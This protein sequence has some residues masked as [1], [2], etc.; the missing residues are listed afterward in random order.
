MNENNSVIIISPESKTC[1]PIFFAIFHFTISENLSMRYQNNSYFLEV[2]NTSIHLKII[3]HTF[4]L[5]GD[6]VT[7]PS[8]AFAP[9]REDP[10]YIKVGYSN[11]LSLIC[12]LPV[13]LQSS[14]QANVVTAMVI[15]PLFNF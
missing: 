6:P 13:V 3:N 5:V 7:I 2:S 14:G 15:F 11:S 1:H 4:Y 12:A 8:I 9:F 10:L